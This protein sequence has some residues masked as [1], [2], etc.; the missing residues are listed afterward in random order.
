MLYID[1][2]IVLRHRKHL[3]VH[4]TVYICNAAL[5]KQ[6]TL[7]Q[8]KRLDTVVYSDDQI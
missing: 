3:P 7:V 1:K 6:M 8:N 2:R 5:T 4:R